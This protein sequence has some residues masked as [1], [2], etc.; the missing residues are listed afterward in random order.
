MFENFYWSEKCLS[1]LY[2]DVTKDDVQVVAKDTEGHV[3]MLQ[4]KIDVTYQECFEKSPYIKVR[5]KK[6]LMKLVS[7]LI[8]KDSCPQ[9]CVRNYT[10]G[11]IDFVPFSK[12]QWV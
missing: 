12:I 5:G 10:S 7:I 9:A 11:R 2:Y 3:K 1:P 4:A 8:N 6:R